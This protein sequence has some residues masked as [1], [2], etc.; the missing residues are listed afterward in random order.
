MKQEVHETG[1]SSPK[2]YCRGTQH[3]KVMHSSCSS[4]DILTTK[5]RDQQSCIALLWYLQKKALSCIQT[6]SNSPWY[7]RLI[8]A[9]NFFHKWAPTHDWQPCSLFQ[10][11]F[12]A[13]QIHSERNRASRL[14]GFF[15]TAAPRY[16]HHRYLYQGRDLNI[17]V[18]WLKENPEK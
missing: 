1:V 6:Q 11:I 3:L 15:C 7:L 12:K 18:T 8:S 16:R 5:T 9:P 14:I 4:P 2:K 10:S 13:Q 17:K